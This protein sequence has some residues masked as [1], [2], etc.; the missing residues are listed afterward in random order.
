[1]K[2]SPRFS[3]YFLLGIW[4]LVLALSALACSLGGITISNNTATIDVNLTQAQLNGIFQK[5]N[6]HPT[7]RSDDFLLDRVTGVE[8]HDGFIR[9]IGTAPKPGAAS[10]PGSYDVSLGA[11]NDRLVAKV[12]AVSIPGVEMNDPRIVNANQK[13][14][15][16]LSKTVTDTNGDA[17]FKE[18]TVKEGGLT[19]KIEVNLKNK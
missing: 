5:A 12:V 9:V 14:E 8:L 7:D 17:K 13:L 3:S 4:L 16:E 18:A 19:M 2:P 10:V 6:E 11:Q 15:T 1:M